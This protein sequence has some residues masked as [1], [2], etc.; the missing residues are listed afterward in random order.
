MAHWY[1]NGRLLAADDPVLIQT[2][3]TIRAERKKAGKP[4][5][6]AKDEARIRLGAVSGVT[7]ILRYV[8]SPD[9]LLN[10]RTN[11]GI[12]AAIQCFAGVEDPTAAQYSVLHWREE[13]QDAARKMASSAAT[14][15]VEFHKAI[16]EHLST[17]VLPTGKVQQHA[18][19][20]VKDLIDE[21]GFH[22]GEA[23]VGFSIHKGAFKYGG[24][25]DW[26]HKPN[27]VVMD[28]K[29]VSKPRQPYLH[30]AAQAAAYGK[31]QFGDHPFSAF[32][33]YISQDD[34]RIDMVKHWSPRELAAGWDLFQLAY[35][36]F[37]LFKEFQP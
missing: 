22:P 10:W 37:Y 3:K 14:L 28:W 11:I 23:E 13:A 2:A 18:S 1:L 25:I 21:L 27:K 15:G 17:G 5:T 7:D 30:E 29:T 16:E 6:G 20:V 36:A 26:L 12:D 34:G 9:G 8:G 24:T 4:G 35:K 32:N 33:V 31:S 19:K